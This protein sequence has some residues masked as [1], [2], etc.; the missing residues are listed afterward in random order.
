M[1]INCE[2]YDIDIGPFVIKMTPKISSLKEVTI[3]S[4]GGEDFTIFEL[5]PAIADNV[6]MQA[7]SFNMGEIKQLDV[8]LEIVQKAGK[9]ISITVRKGRAHHNDPVNSG[10]VI[11]TIKDYVIKFE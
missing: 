2:L 11:F 5:G 6:V 8:C 9:W 4:N 7:N 1:L 10:E 3:Q